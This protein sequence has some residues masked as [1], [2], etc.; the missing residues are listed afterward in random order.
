MTIL[1]AFLQGVLQG[2]TEFLPVSSSGHLSLFQYFSGHAGDTGFLFS[3]LLHAGTLVA[4]CIL[5][6]RTILEL[7]VEGLRLLGI[8]LPGGCSAGG[9]GRSPPP[10]GCS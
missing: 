1:Q 2:L 4:V 6:W 3:I 7:I 9:C 8:S 10:G 5:F